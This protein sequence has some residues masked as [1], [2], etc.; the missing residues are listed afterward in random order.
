MPAKGS[1]ARQVPCTCLHCGKA[2][3][4]YASKVANGRARYCSTDCRKHGQYG[5][6]P[7]PVADRFWAKVAVAG[8]DD[9]WLWTAGQ[10]IWGYGNIG[11]ENGQMRMA[12]RISW[13]LH[14]GPIPRGLF[15][16]HHCD[17]PPC[18]NPAHLFIGPPKINTQD[19]ISKGR[20]GDTGAKGERNGHA[21]L[22]AEQV[23]EIR[24]ST[25]PNDS[26]L[27]RH[28]GVSPTTVTLARKGKTWRHL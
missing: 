23:R 6:T 20:H 8:P 13:E 9:C 16:C 17:N 24:A 7:T 10:T 14:Y 1:T 2:F 12:H 26:D 28:Y 15:V 11:T 25:N 18:V 22:T 19:M 27:A 3:T 21:K 4:A 5:P